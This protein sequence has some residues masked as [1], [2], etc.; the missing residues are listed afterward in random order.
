MMESNL[1]GFSYIKGGVAKCAHHTRLNKRL[2]KPFHY[3]NEV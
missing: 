2:I 3:N 1:F